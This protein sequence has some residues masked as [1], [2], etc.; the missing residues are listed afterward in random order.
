MSQINHHTLQ[1]IINDKAAK[2]FQTRGDSGDMTAKCQLWYGL[3]PVQIKDNCGKIWLRF[4]IW[5]SIDVSFIILITVFWLCRTRAWFLGYIYWN[6]Q[7]LNKWLLGTGNMDERGWGQLLVMK[8][9]YSFA[10]VV[11]MLV[12]KFAKT[13]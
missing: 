12:H 2:L 3:D 7:K 1:N 13:Q 11:V 4:V 5:Y 10:G 8:M 9:S 6:M